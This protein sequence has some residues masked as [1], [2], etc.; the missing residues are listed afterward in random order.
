MNSQFALL[1]NFFKFT[2]ETKF[3]IDYSSFCAPNWT[4]T[5]TISF[6]D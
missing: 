5:N 6:G 1:V 4:R 2:C 3:T